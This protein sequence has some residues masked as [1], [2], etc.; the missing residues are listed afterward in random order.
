MILGRTL[1]CF[2]KKKLRVVLIS[3]LNVKITSRILGMN[4]DDKDSDSVNFEK[5]RTLV[6]F[7]KTID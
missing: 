3:F 4:Q 5:A 6:F 1:V 2:K 7:N